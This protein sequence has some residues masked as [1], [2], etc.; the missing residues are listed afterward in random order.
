M[1]L[2]FKFEFLLTEEFIFKRQEEQDRGSNKKG[3]PSNCMIM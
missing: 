2:D 3:G 1:H